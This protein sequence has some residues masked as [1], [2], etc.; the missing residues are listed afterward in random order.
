MDFTT[1]LIQRIRQLAF[2]IIG[3]L[4][5]ANS[6]VAKTVS[7]FAIVIDQAHAAALQ[8]ELATY[9]KVLEED[10]LRV[11]LL[12]DNWTSPEPIRAQL[13][14]LYQEQALE[15]AVFIGNIPVPMI[16]DAQHLTSTFKMPQ[17]LDWVISSVPSDRYY[18]DF[19]LQFTFLKKDAKHD[20]LFYYTLNADN[21]HRIQI[22][23]YTGRL[24]PPTDKFSESVEMI[25]AYLQKATYLRKAYNPVDQVATYTAEGYNSNALMSWASVLV[26]FRNQFGPLFEGKGHVSFS[27][28]TNQPFMKPYWLTQ[29][30]RK[31]LDYAYFNGHGLADQ[32][33]VSAE[34]TVSSPTASMQN[35]G[36]YVR[37]QL[38]KAKNIEETKEKLKSS[39]GISEEL[40][41]NAF[42]PKTILED[43]LHKAQQIIGFEDLRNWPI[44]AKL[45]YL[46]ACDNGSY[47]LDHYIAGYYPFS[48]GDNLVTIANSVGVLQDLWANEFMGMIQNGTR[49]G[50]I[51]KHASYLETHLFGDPS[52]HF[53]APNATKWNQDLAHNQSP[54]YWKKQLTSPLP[55][56]QAFALVKLSQLLSKEQATELLYKHFSTNTH[57]VVRTEAYKLLK[58]LQPTNWTQIVIQATKDNFEFLRRIAIYDMAEMGDEVFIDPLIALYLNDQHA[59]RT[60]FKVEGTLDFFDKHKVVEAIQRNTQNRTF[61]DSTMVSSLLT[62]YENGSFLLKY[63]ELLRANTL[64]E[65][66][67]GFVISVLRAYRMHPYVPDVLHF[68]EQ[69]IT[70][71]KHV[72][73]ALEALSWFKQSYQKKSIIQFCQQLTQRSD[74]SEAIRQQAIRTKH[75]LQ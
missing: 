12:V 36:R 53:S 19:D 52:F 18:D 70:N 6:T 51:V 17:H 49:I 69:Q 30:A 66:D 71:E 9:K 39:L 15:G 73:A 62:R 14:R 50:H 32:Q 55:D 29:L 60:L 45:V 4:V 68:I 75:I 31:D 24:K 59:N 25:R 22:D 37:H 61:Y 20:H 16:R 54:S 57:E 11:H 5:M 2:A 48:K 13:H 46:D 56:V 40:F 10:G 43:S 34:P 58:E 27:N 28:Y 8:I 64:P 23:I 1:K 63:Y 41:E 67:F 7:S 44:N 42:D 33:I 21:A 3:V 74:I 26:G 38:R 35:V 47:H 65:K 72:I